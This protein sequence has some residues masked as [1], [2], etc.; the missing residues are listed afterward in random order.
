MLLSSAFP[1]INSLCNCSVREPGRSAGENSRHQICGKN[2][3]A[4]R[5]L[6]KAEQQLLGSSDGIGEVEIAAA[7]VWGVF[8]LS[9]LMPLEIDACDILFTAFFLLGVTAGALLSPVP[10]S[11]GE[12]PR[13][14]VWEL[15]WVQSLIIS[16]KMQ[17]LKRVRL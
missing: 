11:G 15:Y 14:G 17:F 5:S 4:S 8:V 7:I 3:N 2:W 9:R 6:A 10:L 13:G 1:I 16:I 12:Q